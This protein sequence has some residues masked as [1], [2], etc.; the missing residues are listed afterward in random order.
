VPTTRHLRTHHFFPKNCRV[1]SKT[2]KSIKPCAT[3][4]RARCRPTADLANTGLT[5]KRGTTARRMSRAVRPCH[6]CTGTG[7]APPTF[8]T[9]A[10]RREVALRH[11]LC[12]CAPPCGQST[13]MQCVDAA[14]YH[15]PPCSA[16]FTLSRN[17]AYDAPRSDIIVFCATGGGALFFFAAPPA[18][19]L[20]GAAF[21][22]A[23]EAEAEASAVLAVLSSASSQTSTVPTPR[24]TL[25]PALPG[26]GSPLSH[27]RDWAHPSRITGTGLTPSALPG[28]GS[29]SHICAG[30][31][32]APPIHVCTGITASVFARLPNPLAQGSDAARYTMVCAR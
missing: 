10:Q 20:A 1:R 12:E 6:S 4:P 25:P 29:P 23:A 18:V 16:L 7:L 8:C 15:G 11:D 22:A 9:G 17:P 21:G 26:L 24:R 27:Y 31:G 13:L 32:F 14:S 5:Q 28:P 3:L 2:I 19:A 30:T